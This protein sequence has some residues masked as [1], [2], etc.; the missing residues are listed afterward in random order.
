MIKHMSFGLKNS[1][2]SHSSPN[3]RAVLLFCAVCIVIT[4]Y[5]TSQ[6]YL[7][8][9]TQCADFAVALF[10]CCSC[11]FLPLVC[12]RGVWC[13]HEHSEGTTRHNICMSGH[14]GG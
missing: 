2:N 5:S 8:G 4:V 13:V 1:F 9:L 7:H 10:L 6:Q 3:P 12:L 14:G 11:F